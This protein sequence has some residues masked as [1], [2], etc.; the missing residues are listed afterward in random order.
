M[1]KLVNINCKILKIQSLGCLIKIIYVLYLISWGGGF[2]PQ[3]PSGYAPISYILTFPS[4]TYYKLIFN[5][6]TPVIISP[7]VGLPPM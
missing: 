4:F 1:I 2:I 5:I 7:H 3:S 6:N